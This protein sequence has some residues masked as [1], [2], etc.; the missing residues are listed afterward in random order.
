MRRLFFE[1]V[2]ADDLVEFGE[3]F[4]HLVHVLRISPGDHLE[5]VNNNA[6]CFLVLIESIDTIRHLITARI[7]SRKRLISMITGISM[8]VSL[9]K[10]DFDEMV[11]SLCQ[12]GVDHLYPLICER[13]VVRPDSEKALKMVCRFRDISREAAKQCRGTKAMEIH[14]IMPFKKVVALSSCGVLFSSGGEFASFKTFLNSGVSET[15]N[16]FVFIGP[17][18]D[19]SQDEI[20]V[21]L[22]RGLNTVRLSGNILRT[23][24]AAVV[25][26]ALLLS[27][28]GFL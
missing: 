28:R 1:P 6:D 24:N 21:S 27:R 2:I 9:V 14:E 8:A 13:T 10:R 12:L 16:A 4:H 18:G 26:A 11:D 22:K 7:E 23:G 20:T 25:T 15:E 17:E 19:F 3:D 5:I